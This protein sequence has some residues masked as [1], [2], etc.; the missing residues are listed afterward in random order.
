MKLYLNFWQVTV[1]Q[2]NYTA[3]SAKV[4]IPKALTVN[5]E[6][7]RDDW[8][9]PIFTSKLEIISLKKLFLLWFTVYGKR[10]P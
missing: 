10:Q 8:L 6:R 1:A 9:L 4:V 5:Y 2:N 3:N 7:A